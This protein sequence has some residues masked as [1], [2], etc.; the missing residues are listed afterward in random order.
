MADARTHGFDP[1]EER[2]RIAIHVHL[3]TRKTWPL[4]S[5]FF[6]SLF[7]ERLKNTTSPV[8]CVSTSD[9]EF[10]KPSISTSPVSSSWMMAG[11]SPPLF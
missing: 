9:S 3:R 2:I 7:R 1:H 6:Q 11:T 4:D 8:R 5:P 10:M